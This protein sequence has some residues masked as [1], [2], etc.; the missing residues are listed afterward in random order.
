MMASFA[1]GISLIRHLNQEDSKKVDDFLSILSLG[2]MNNPMFQ[3][4]GPNMVKHDFAPTFP[5]KHCQK[6]MRQ[7]I[8]LAD[9]RVHSLPVAAA[10][11]EL[12]KQAK[13]KGYADNDFSAVIT[14]LESN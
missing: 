3:I 12:Y 4:K 11:N 1:E 5:L 8:A 10:A 14:S 6:D 9:E 2:A 7:A 13:S